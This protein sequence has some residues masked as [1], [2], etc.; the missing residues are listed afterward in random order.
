[1]R[2]A[3]SD[4]THPA[5]KLLIQAAKDQ[6]HEVVDRD[7][8]VFICRGWR[9]QHR[10]MAAPHGCPVIV[11][12]WGWF[13]R[14]NNKEQS[15][16][17]HWQLSLGGLNKIPPPGDYP[18]DRFSATGLEIKH[19][20]P[21]PGGYVLLCGQLHFD[22][23]VHGVDY[24]G[25]LT[26]T[27]T[28]LRS[29]GENVVYRPHPQ[30]GVKLDWKHLSSGP[31]DAALAG[32]RY[33]VTYNSNIGHEALLAGVPVLCAPCAPYAELAGKRCPSKGKRLEYFSRAAYGQWKMDEFA[34]GLRHTLARL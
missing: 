28:K 24:I 1:M 19:R 8:D 17:G 12:E 5:L 16:R 27:M 11:V 13:D 32:A 6:G 9:E 20:A 18:P 23:A 34:E 2:I 33:L 30:G 25:W 15:Y 4:K 3:F 7:P 10:A 31:V 26:R 14:V 29:E 21:N 22:A